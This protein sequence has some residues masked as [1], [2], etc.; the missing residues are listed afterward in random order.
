MWDPQGLTTLWASM[1][2]YSDSITFL[3]SIKR[4]KYCWTISMEMFLWCSCRNIISKVSRVPRL[5]QL[6][7]VQLNEV[8]WSSCL[9]SERVQLSVVSWQSACEEKTRKL[10][11]NGHQPRTQLV[12][13]PVEK[14]LHGWLWQEDQ[15]AGSWKVP[16]GKAVARKQLVEI[17]IDWDTSLCVPVICKI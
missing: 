15:S 1:A 2:G 7:A 14:V 12:E 6:S 11:W 5:S 4:S 16:T 9:V 3:V 8:T 10:L 17:V 13:V